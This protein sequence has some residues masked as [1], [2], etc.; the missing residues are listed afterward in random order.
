MDSTQHDPIKPRTITLAKERPFR[1]GAVEVRPN[2]RELIGPDGRT[3][4]EPRVMKVLV[5][6]ARAQGEILTRDDLTETCW[7]G[8][9]VGEDAISRVISRLR[10]ATDLVG[11]DDWTVETIT[12]VGYR[13]LPAG[14]DPDAASA[15]PPPPSLPRPDRRRVLAVSGGAG[16]AALGAG[17]LVWRM[18]PPPV[19]AH[20]RLLY[21]KGVEAL[22]S[23][24]PE[25]NQQAQGFLREAVADAPNYA[26]AWGA[27][28]I[29]YQAS[30][31]FTEPPRQAGVTAQA[32]AAAQRARDLNPNDA[33]AA[34]A[35]ALL[36]NPYRNWTAAERLYQHALSLHARDAQV[37]FIYARFLTGVGRMKDAVVHAQASVA[38][39][40]FAVWHHHVLGLALWAAGRIDE[41]DLLVSKALTRWPRH[42]ALWFLRMNIFTY[43]GQP[44][45]AVAMGE[46]VAA[47]PLNIPPADMDLSLMVPR[48]LASGARN[49]IDAAANQQLA[50]AKR[51]AGYAENALGFLAA[52]GRLDDAFAVARTMY[53]NA[54]SAPNGQRFSSGRYV[55]GGRRQTYVLFLPSAR[56][57]WADPRFPA[58]MRDLGMADYWRA[59]RQRPDDPSWIPA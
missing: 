4:L 50:S 36:A 39:D 46:D 20:A 12:K 18:L 42:Y 27:L 45:R 40:E 35:V 21:A 3:R 25:D 59:S 7:D 6:L 9:I 30:L 47:R 44:D 58:L 57:M 13:L 22:K 32:L 49:Q 17:V 55:V 53:F 1:L 14:H 2:T 41:A 11:R 37:E 56:A 19:P 52:A 16:L 24:L 8:R 48:A 5:A 31:L 10:Q 43:S 51:G 29:A 28:A 54:G 26:E 15:P 38:G 23:G 34:A 33:Q